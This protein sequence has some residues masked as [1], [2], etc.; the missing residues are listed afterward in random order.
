[1][2]TDFDQPD[3]SLPSFLGD[4]PKPATQTQ[5]VT[6]RRRLGLVAGLS[7]VAA[8]AGV[9]IAVGARKRGVLVGG[10]AALAL[11]ALRW[12]LARWFTETPAFAVENRMAG[13]ELRR[14]PHQI[15]ARVAVDEPELEAAL[16]RGFG[17]LACYVYGANSGSEDLEMVT[18]VLTSM[19]DGT[20]TMAFV[21]PPGRTLD[22]LPA[23]D[24]H[25]VVL[26]EVPERRIAS[27]AFRGPFT[28]KNIDKH[29]TLLLRA[30]VTAGMSTRGSV[31][32]AG[33][34]SPTTL[35]ILRRNEVWIEVV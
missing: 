6:R 27:L 12:Q 3:A 14:Y 2:D 5:Q 10:A 11:G 33:Y 28:R 32:F 25:R 23:P 22:S 18:P 30:L 16:D 15:E 34:D 19:R 31:A 24:D 17:R 35:P 8:G 1:M 7:L 29:E 21:M 13:I 26:R 9:A 4:L 20:Y